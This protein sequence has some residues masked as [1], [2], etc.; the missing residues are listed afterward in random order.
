MRILRKGVQG[1]DVEA[2]Q[3]FLRGLTPYSEDLIVNGIFDERTETDTEI[4]KNANGLP[5]PEVVDERTYKL[6]SE[7]YE[8]ELDGRG[9]TTPPKPTFPPLNQADRFATFGQFRFKPNPVAGNPEQIQILDGWAGQNIVSTEIPELHGVEGTFGQKKFQ[10]HKLAAAKVVELF[11]T[12][13]RE[14]LKGHILTW[15]GSFN[16]R[17]IR[18]SRS[19]LSNHAHGTAFDINVAWN[20]LGRTPAQFGKRGS[21]RELVTIANELGFYWGGH[22]QDR[23]D[24]MHF[25]LAKLV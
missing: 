20:G 9:A 18:G 21:V 10:F 14:G 19:V 2:W 22:W 23:P 8:F 17:F 24:G 4:F 15:G 6:A 16:P 13:E 12:W 25:E 11:S 3:L 5:N 7:S 1:K